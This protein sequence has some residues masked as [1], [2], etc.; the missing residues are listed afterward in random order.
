MHHKENFKVL[1]KCKPANLNQ[2]S[3]IPNFNH[4]NNKS[5]HLNGLRVFL[6]GGNRALPIYITININTIHPHISILKVKLF[7]SNSISTN[8]I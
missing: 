5:V 8:M 4:I 6:E 1:L 3:F 2:S 7:P